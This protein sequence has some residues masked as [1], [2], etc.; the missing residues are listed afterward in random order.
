MWADRISVWICW[1]YR[2]TDDGDAAFVMAVM[3]VTVMVMVLV[4]VQAHS[5]D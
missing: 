1:A 5:F 2:C 3:I 4:L